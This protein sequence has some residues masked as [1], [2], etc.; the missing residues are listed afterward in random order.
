[1]THPLATA[2]QTRV[3]RRPAADLTVKADADGA[4]LVIDQDG[5]AREINQMR[6]AGSS[7]LGTDEIL[8]LTR[9]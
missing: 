9:A 3:L 7:E 1:M 5:A 2:R 4:G 6:G 8:A